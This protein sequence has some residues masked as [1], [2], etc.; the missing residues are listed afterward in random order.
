MNETN[1]CPAHFET[2]LDRTL[3]QSAETLIQPP[4]GAALPPLPAGR[5]RYV[6]AANDLFIQAR[7]PCVEASVLLAPL[8]QGCPTAWPGKAYGWCMDPCQMTCGMN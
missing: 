6:L 2:P 3:F 8:R 4:S 7:T 1:A 5:L